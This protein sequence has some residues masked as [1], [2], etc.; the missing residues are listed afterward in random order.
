MKHKGTVS[1]VIQKYE[2][3]GNVEHNY[4]LCPKNSIVKEDI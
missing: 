1:K 2:N 4:S 3:Q